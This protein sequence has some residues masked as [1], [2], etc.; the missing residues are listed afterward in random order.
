MLVLMSKLI[1]DSFGE[2]DT[3]ISEKDQWEGCNSLLVF[4]ISFL[5][6]LF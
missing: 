3:R 1:S 2:L 6:H 4:L 5:V